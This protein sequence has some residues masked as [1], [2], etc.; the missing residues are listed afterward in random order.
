MSEFKSTV[1]VVA[2]QRAPYFVPKPTY[3]LFYTRQ[4]YIQTNKTNF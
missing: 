1:G 2:N 4:D 3:L